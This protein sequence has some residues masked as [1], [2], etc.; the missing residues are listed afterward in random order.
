MK[1][2]HQF[3]IEQSLT[4]SEAE[5]VL[6]LTGSYTPD[7]VKAAYKKAAILNHP[8]K[9]GSVSDMQR[10]NAAYEKLKNSSGSGTKLDKSWW[11]NVRKKDEEF[12][13]VAFEKVKKAVNLKSYVDHFEKIFGE[14]ITAEQ[15]E[16]VMAGAHVM[17]PWSSLNLRFKNATNTTVIDLVVSVHAYA[18][19]RNTGLGMEGQEIEVF[20]TPEIFHNRQK[21]KLTRSRYTTESDYKFLSNPEKIFPAKKLGAKKDKAPGKFSKKDALIT[22]EKE[23]GARFRDDYLYV[24]LPNIEAYKGDGTLI[25]Y[26]TVFMGSA[27]WGGN[28]IYA[29]KYGG[30]KELGVATFF[31]SETRAS[32]SWFTDELKKI[33]QLK[34][35]EEVQTALRQAGEYYKAHRSQIDPERG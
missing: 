23:L 9:G 29:G 7:E 1:N 8:D 18:R 24:P 10:V 26:R 13:R 33:Q 35:P 11:E 16:E 3:L 5:K 4:S 17:S 32:M 30:R 2:F 22:F 20:V 6:G 28:G 31:I 15:T 19:N 27:S 12:V 25:L 14:K 21:I 34:T